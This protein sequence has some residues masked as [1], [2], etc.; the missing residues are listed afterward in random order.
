MSPGNVLSAGMAVICFTQRSRRLVGVCMWHRTGRTS[1]S[2]ES[3][4]PGLCLE[5][6]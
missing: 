3:S 6:Q 4:T 2:S 1:V 5:A